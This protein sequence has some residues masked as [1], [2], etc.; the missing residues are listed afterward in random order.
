MSHPAWICC[1]LGA[2]EY[3]AIPRALHQARQLSLLLTDAWVP[4]NSLLTKLPGASFKALQERYHPDLAQA[5]VPGFNNSLL[6]FELTQ[7]IRRT[8]GWERMIARN[9]WF[10]TQTLRQLKQIAPKFSKFGDRPIL[11]TYSYAALDLLRF[12]KQQG[13]YTVLGQIDPGIAEEKIVLEEY[14]AHPDLA[15]AWKPTPDGYWA[16]WRQECDLADC[17]LVNSSWSKQ[18]LEEAGINANK[19]EI[20]PLVYD[21]PSAAS[22]FHRSYPKQFTTDRPLKAL[23][24]GLVTL[25]KGVAAL[26]DTIKR[27]EGKPIE[28][29]M[30]GSQQIT[31]PVELQNHPQVHW[32]EHVPRSQTHQYYQQADVFLF[33]TLSDGFGLTQLE[34][35]AWKLPII[36]SQSCGEVVVNGIN[37]LRLNEIT[38]EAIATYLLDLLRYPDR[39][40]Q[41]SDQSIHPSQCSLNHLSNKLQSLAIKLSN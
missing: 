4:P 7:R 25:R 41:L 21:P 5:P 11:F 16:R 2:R 36:A 37:G 32:V 1:Q 35:Q 26:L 29:W 22:Q 27:L 12:A 38:G 3:Y 6:Q 14:T 13:W 19:V 33:P 9:N 8:V 20:V 24:L 18:L 34:A 31:I 23:F 28:F 40:Q 17:I 15:P 30:V 10:Q 39:L